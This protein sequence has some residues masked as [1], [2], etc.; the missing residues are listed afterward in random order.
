[1]PLN[2]CDYDSKARKAIKAFWQSRDDAKKKQ[3]A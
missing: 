3:T 1:M 2:L